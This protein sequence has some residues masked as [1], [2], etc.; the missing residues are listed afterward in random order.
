MIPLHARRQL[1]IGA[2]AIAIGACGGTRAAVASAARGVDR[3]SVLLSNRPAPSP[4]CR[5]DFTPSTLPAVSQ[6]FDSA[7][8]MNRLADLKSDYSTADDST[9]VLLSLSFDRSGA[10]EDV[11]QV[12]YWAPPE[13]I[14]EVE[15][16]VRE[17]VAPQRSELSA[18][19]RVQPLRETPLLVGRSELCPPRSGIRFQVTAGGI[20]TPTTPPS[21]VVRVLVDEK[22]RVLSANLVSGTGDSELDRWVTDVILRHTYAPGLRDEKPVEMYIEERVDIRARP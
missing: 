14:G 7:R 5:V 10:L 13:L 3:P 22:G 16:A 2:L 8:V 4:E 9:Y 11:H 20:I 6:L 21:V 17:S 19:V 15:R 12:D 1:L 18:R